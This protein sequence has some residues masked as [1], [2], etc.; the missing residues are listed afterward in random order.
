M[1][2]ELWRRGGGERVIICLFEKNRE[3]APFLNQTQTGFKSSVKNSRARFHTVHTT[4]KII[5]VLKKFN[6]KTYEELSWIRRP[7][8][9]RSLV[10]TVWP[11]GKDSE[12]R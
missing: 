10:L 11:R 4:F 2:L 8:W 7:A 12:Y 3:I 5:P 9:I 1:K 6:Y